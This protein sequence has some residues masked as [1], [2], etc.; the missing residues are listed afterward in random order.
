[1][2]VAGVVAAAFLGSMGA[3]AGVAAEAGSIDAGV[4]V[5]PAPGP[6]RVAVPAYIFSNDLRGWEAIIDESRDTAV[7]VVNP[8]NGP[9][10][11][12][13]I[14]CEGF[15]PPDDPGTGPNL[16]GLRVDDTFV[17]LRFP[18]DPVLDPLSFG[19]LATLENQF[20]RRATALRNASIRTYGYVWSNTNG[21]DPWCSRTAAI[22][23][24]EID[25]YRNI[26]GITNVFFDD[27]SPACPNDD[28]RAMV[29]V[30]RGKG[31]QV[32]LN[33]GTVSGGC[34]AEE[35][36]V[37]VNF[38]GLPATYTAMRDALVA[39]AKILRQH[40]P[41]IR[42]WHIVHGAADPDVA[43]IVAQAQVT[44]DYLFITDDTTQAHGCDRGT[45]N[46][47][48]LYG[49]WPVVRLDS[50]SCAGRSN[51]NSYSWE[52]IVDA[53]TA[54]VPAVRASVISAGP[55][56][57]PV[58]RTAVPAAGSGTTPRGTVPR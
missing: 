13:G 21:A 11:Y 38:E 3:T 39:N 4:V 2:A 30:A 8:R 29:N 52:T 27:A 40:N 15:P 26:Y 19:Y 41:A 22:V 34:L 20:V 25:S 16:A 45:S 58:G 46:F 33:A 17:S 44:G 7:V 53:T 42:I 56:S 14:H 48:A 55:P 10:V 50:V 18:N 28:R 24:D 5:L 43:A 12:S 23:A 37:V 49:T 6:L 54:P 9:R 1:M 51:G 57:A 35:A 31:A 36:D 47:D 32:I